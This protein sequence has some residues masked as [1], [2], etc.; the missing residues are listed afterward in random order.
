MLSLVL[1]F[2]I[3][4]KL[5]NVDSLDHLSDA[6]G[7]QAFI[8][9]LISNVFRLMNLEYGVLPAGNNAYVEPNR[10]S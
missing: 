10:Y 3:P 8:P 6:S 7:R 4:A 9:L 2:T 5:I 1:F